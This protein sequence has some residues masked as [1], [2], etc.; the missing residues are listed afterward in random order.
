MVSMEKKER[1]NLGLILLFG[2]NIVTKW[3][4]GSV[5][6]W[7]LGYCNHGDYNEVHQVMPWFNVD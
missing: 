2:N 5:T 4:L 7:L 6:R 1:T 3:L